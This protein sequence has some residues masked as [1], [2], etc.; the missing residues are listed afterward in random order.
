MRAETA[1]NAQK[2]HG[3]ILKIRLLV[4]LLV[5]PYLLQAF[6]TYLDSK[7][8]S[9]KDLP[10]VLMHDSTFGN[11]CFRKQI[12]LFVQKPVQTPL[13]RRPS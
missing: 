11:L 4:C 13:A 5:S 3:V 10:P 2:I 7:V 8:L 1:R 12:P 9:L 6:V